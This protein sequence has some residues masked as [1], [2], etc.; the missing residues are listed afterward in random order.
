MDIEDQF[1]PYVLSSLSF[2]APAGHMS[3]T[4][5][6]LDNLRTFSGTS[7]RPSK[8]LFEQEPAPVFQTSTFNPY[9][10]VHYNNPNFQPKPWTECTEITEAP[11]SQVYNSDD[12]IWQQEF[13]EGLGQDQ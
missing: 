6:I 5:L 7:F 8:H 11:L 9:N 2:A 10:E 3:N 1:V 4:S 13:T 12:S